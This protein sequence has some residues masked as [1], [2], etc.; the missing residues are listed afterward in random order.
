MFVIRTYLTKQVEIVECGLILNSRVIQS[1]YY[2]VMI[3]L[4]TVNIM[5]N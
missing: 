3:T 1:Q 2:Y 4:K 5:P